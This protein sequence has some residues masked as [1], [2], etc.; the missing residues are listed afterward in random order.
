[1]KDAFLT[2]S[3]VNV[4]IVDWSKGNKFPYGQAAANTRVVGAMIAI[5]ITAIATLKNASLSSFH[6][7]GQSLGA[8]TAGFAGKFLGNQT[9]GQIT[10]M[11]PAGPNFEG[12]PPEARLWYTDA[13]FVDAIH[14]D[15]RPVIGLGMEEACGTVDFYP[16]GGR[17]QPGCGGWQRFSSFAYGFGNG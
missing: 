6:I 9:L 14:T 15:I 1:M 7:I 10:G 3:D 13:Q 12:T 16:N 4:I 11:D 2:A 5:Q 8:H 17:S